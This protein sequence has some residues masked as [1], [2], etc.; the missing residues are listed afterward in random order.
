M[1]EKNLG[2]KEL[3]LRLVDELYKEQNASVFASLSK[4]NFEELFLS[5]DTLM[6]RVVDKLTEYANADG[7]ELTNEQKEE[8]FRKY[9]ALL[10]EGKKANAY[11]E[12]MSIPSSEEVKNYVSGVMAT[13]DR[14]KMESTLLDALSKEA[15]TKL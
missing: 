12:I 15:G 11:I 2:V 3:A 5:R 10:D 13:M 1:S 14:A 8:E 6:K 9:I 4:R 7:T